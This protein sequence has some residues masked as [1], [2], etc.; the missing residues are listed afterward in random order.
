MPYRMLAFVALA[1][2]AAPTALAEED[3]WTLPRTPWDDPDLHGV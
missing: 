1:V 2:C 3:E